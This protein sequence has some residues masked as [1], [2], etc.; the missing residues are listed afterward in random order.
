[1]IRSLVVCAKNRSDTGG[2]YGR[3]RASWC[4]GSAT[5]A[6]Y[7]TA[8][9]QDWPSHRR[10]SKLE[11]DVSANTDNEE[12][13]N[14]HNHNDNSSNTKRDKKNGVGG[15]ADVT[16]PKC[17]CELLFGILFCCAFY[18]CVYADRRDLSEMSQ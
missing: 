14:D 17:G 18:V 15:K 4:S 12:N 10:P 2:R 9:K 5:T 8:D 7:Q 13:N 1:M 3:Y 11:C 6:D 16:E